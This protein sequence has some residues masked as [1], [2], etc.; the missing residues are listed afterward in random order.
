M[1]NWPKRPTRAEAAAAAI[2]ANCIAHAPPRLLVLHGSIGRRSTIFGRVVGDRQARACPDT[3]Y[4]MLACSAT[5]VNRVVVWLCGW[6]VRV[7]AQ[8]SVPRTCGLRVVPLSP[9]AP[10]TAQ[11]KGPR[12]SCVLGGRRTRHRSGSDW[13]LRRPGSCVGMGFV[14][15]SSIG[16]KRAACI[17]ARGI[18]PRGPQSRRRRG[19]SRCRPIHVN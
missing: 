6:P 14:G 7:R 5:L 12:K 8:S 4:L 10:A 1:P 17:L 18:A 19:D 9:A 2:A 15:R 13:T 11:K 3:D 16:S